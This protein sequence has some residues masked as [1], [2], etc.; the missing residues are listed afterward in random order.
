MDKNL[1]PMDIIDFWYSDRIKKQWFNSTPALDNEI[2]DRYE[3]IWE[4]ALSGKLDNWANSPQGC[5]ALIIILD[6]FPLNMFRGKAKSFCS[7][8]KAV[9]IANNAISNQFDLQIEKEKL[10][11][12]YM[13]FMHSENINHQDLSVKLYKE[14][15]LDA[16]M[17]FVQHHR[18]LIK[19]FGRF[20]HRNQ[21]LGR[22]NSKDEI[23]YL[24]SKKAFLG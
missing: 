2:L 14:S 8:K 4:Y 13:P 24:S 10:A 22:I 5:L 16:N 1:L 18:D 12:L 15:H 17:R 11:F 23:T 9:E 20:P 7:E 21:I 3:K 6:Q 19:K